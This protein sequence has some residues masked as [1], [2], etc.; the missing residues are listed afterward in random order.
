MPLADSVHCFAILFSHL[1]TY[2]CFSSVTTCFYSFT[3]R[4]YFFANRFYL[5]LIVYQLFLPVSTCLS[6]ASRFSACVPMTLNLMSGNLL[7]IFVN[8]NILNLKISEVSKGSQTS[9]KNNVC[10][11]INQQMA[12]LNTEII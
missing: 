2:I 7:E 12:R 3:I 10:P 5:F 4:F 1:L 9:N 8:K 11:I 6:T